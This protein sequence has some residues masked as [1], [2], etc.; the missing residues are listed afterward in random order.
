MVS[1]QSMVFV[2]CTNWNS[3]SQHF[4]KAIPQ[5]F[6][7]NLTFVF[8]IFN[9]IPQT[10]DICHISKQNTTRKQHCGKFINNILLIDY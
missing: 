3:A 1:G 9:N 4:W 5:D 10:P 7:S 8:D 6:Y 2:A